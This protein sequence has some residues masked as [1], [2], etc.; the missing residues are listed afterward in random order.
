VISK[1]M[2]RTTFGS[3]RVVSRVVPFLLASFQFLVPAVALAQQTDTGRPSTVSVSATERARSQ[4][5]SAMHALSGSSLSRESLDAAESDSLIFLFLPLATYGSGGYAVNIA[6]TDVNRDGKPDLVV[7]NC[8]ES[9]SICDAGGSGSG[10]GSVG[11]LLGNGDGTFQPAVVYNS[12]GFGANSVAVADV[13]GDGKPDLVVSNC[14]SESDCF[15]TGLVG[16]LLGNGDGTFQPATTYATGGAYSGAGA[17][18]VAV[19]DVNGDGKPDLLVSNGGAGGLFGSVGVLL[20]NGDGTFQPAVD[21]AAFGNGESDIGAVSVAV[22]DV[23]GDGKLDLVVGGRCSAVD[24]CG[25]LIAVL[26]G[27]GDGTFQS[28]TTF[29]S[30]D[31]LQSSVAVGD[32]NGDGNPDLLVANLS[33]GTVGVMLGNG[34]GTFKPIVNYS[35]GASFSGGPMSVTASDVNGDGKL[36]L[37]ASSGGMRLLLGNGDGTFQPAVLYDP[38]FGVRIA[39][40]VEDVNGDGKPDVAMVDY[41]G[42]AGVLLNNNGAPPTTTSLASSVNPGAINQTVT[43]TATV[44]PQSG[45]TANGTVVFMDGVYVEGEVPLTGNQ[46]QL[47]QSYTFVSPH[48]VTAYYSGNL[49]NAAGSISNTLAES[50]KVDP[51]TTA[52]T[53]SKNPAGVNGQVTYTAIVTNPYGAVSGTITFKDGGVTVATVNVSS[54]EAKYHVSYPTIGMRTITATYSGNQNDAASKSAPLIEDIDGVS[55]TTVTT[56]ESPSFIGQSVVFTAKVTS[57]YGSIP[58]GEVVTFYS[59]SAVIGTGTTA[60]GLASLTTSS[61]APKAYTVKA[62]YAGSPIFKPS[63]GSVKQVVNLYPTTTG[64]SSSVNPSAHEQAVT[65]SATVTSAG[66]ETPTGKVSFKDGTAGIGTGTLSGGVATLTKSNLGVRT[67][68]ITAVYDGDDQSGRSTSPALSQVV[69]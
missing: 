22:A 18:M 20:G 67:H 26:L 16:V 60:S 33:S 5:Q 38:P 46:A 1:I 10:S 14:G 56:S 36:D 31:P 4:A 11:V 29:P 12:G 32:V 52:L 23:N 49:N 59:N 34:N 40:T 15:G 37:L 39:S 2:T 53:S 3:I 58:N 43:Y 66:P 7:A 54:N 27:N 21:Y 45:G 62:T 17:G 24:N 63:S 42:A 47:N 48:S 51:T 9:S 19:A 55:K 57:V 6:L 50:V 30:D 25:N 8:D 44:T 41:G 68:S 35:V 69:N 64:L 28:P 13:N 65:F 61:L